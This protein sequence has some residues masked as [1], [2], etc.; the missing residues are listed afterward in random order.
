M[1]LEECYSKFGGDYMNVRK[2]LPSDSVIDRF[3]V[4]FQKEPTM[5]ELRKAVESGD[6]KTAFTAAHT[7]KGLASNIG[8]TALEKTAGALTEQLRPL[9]S[10]PDH[11]LYRAVEDSYGLIMRTID[12]YV[13]E[14]AEILT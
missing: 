13:A 12:Q 11:E 14:S 5:N 9:E 8:F 2:R 7:L 6:I 10:T 1:T 3:V 4:K